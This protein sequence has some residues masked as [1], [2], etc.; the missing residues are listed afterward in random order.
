MALA[1]RNWLMFSTVAPGLSNLKSSSLSAKPLEDNFCF[2][3]AEA[4]LT[5]SC[6]VF[7]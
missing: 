1:P 6:F 2:L 4:I 3:T 7:P 5:L